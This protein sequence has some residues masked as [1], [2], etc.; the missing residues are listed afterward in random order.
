MPNNAFFQKLRQDKG[1]RA[2]AATISIMFLLLTAIILTTVIANR[3]TGAPS[4][5]DTPSADVPTSLSDPDDN[6]PPQTPPEESD[7][8]SKPTDTAPTRFLLPVA[9]V[10]S[11]AHDPALQVF[12]PTMGDYRVHLGVDIAT[13][14][15][16]SV[17]AM[18]D[19]TVAQVWED[20]SMGQCVAI[21]HENEVYT[22]YKNLSPALAAGIEA[23][24][25]VKA[26]DVIGTVGQSAMVEVAQDPHLHLE[27][28]AGGL[29]VNPLDYLDEQALATLR[30]DTNF[31]DVS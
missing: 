18:A 3:K 22:V 23:G 15:G 5:Y 7:K 21:K 16:A 29:Q 27:M 14:A 28:T 1:T 26:G 19:G 2:V 10:M 6:S 20:V 13:I 17:C 8:P 12:S 4:D 11:N 31:E 25:V 24:A 9:G 30:E